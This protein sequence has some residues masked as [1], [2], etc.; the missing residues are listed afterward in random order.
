MW[1]TVIGLV[2]GWLKPD[3]LIIL[4]VLGPAVKT[5][6]PIFRFFLPESWCDPKGKTSIWLA[7]GLSVLAAFGYKAAQHIGIWA[8]PDVLMTLGVGF[9]VGCSA[10]G[11][12]VTVQAVKG[13]NVNIQKLKV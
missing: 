4:A 8:F 1:E 5:V 9:L 12:N 7:F 3:Y 10:I 11:Y 13:N 2:Q 6:L